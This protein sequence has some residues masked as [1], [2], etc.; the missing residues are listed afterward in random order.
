MISKSPRTVPLRA[1][2]GPNL[3]SNLASNAEKNH[4]KGNNSVILKDKNPKKLYNLHIAIININ[5][6]L[7]IRIYNGYPII[8]YLR[9][10]GITENV[11]T[12]GQKKFL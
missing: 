9:Q 2:M 3:E 1:K 11:A 12:L 4:R 6:Y 10:T 7:W 8:T 5:P